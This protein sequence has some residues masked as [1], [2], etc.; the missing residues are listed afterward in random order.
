M[1]DADKVSEKFELILIFRKWLKL[2]DKALKKQSHRD[3]G[4][5][6]I[7]TKAKA[8]F[9]P[10]RLIS[11]TWKAIVLLILLSCPTPTI[12][13]IPNVLKSLKNLRRRGKEQQEWELNSWDKVVKKTI[14]AMAETSL[15]SSY[16]ICVIDHRYP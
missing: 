10:V 11:I 8:R 9:L 13:C 14:Y 4:S 12:I 6:I 3:L 5:K 2:L 15:Q 7:D 16:H 1:C